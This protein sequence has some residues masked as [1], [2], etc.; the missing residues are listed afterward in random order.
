MMDR[1]QAIDLLGYDPVA[2]WTDFCAD[3]MGDVL[4]V[5][6][7]VEKELHTAVDNMAD[8]VNEEWPVHVD[9][10]MA[11]SSTNLK[12]ALS[13]YLNEEGRTMFVV[14]SLHIFATSVDGP[15]ATALALHK[16]ITDIAT[17]L[18][19]KP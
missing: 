18:R 12:G 15:P 19:G 16:A 17:K 9:D 10:A 1:N 13:D 14:L 8:A 7:E 5:H 4:D 6:P 2:K 3:F 11:F